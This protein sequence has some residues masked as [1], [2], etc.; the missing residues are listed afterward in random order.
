MADLSVVP[1]RNG[2]LNMKRGFDIGAGPSRGV[3]AAVRVLE[4]LVE[5]GEL[6]E[7]SVRRVAWMQDWETIVLGEA[8]VAQWTREEHG[9][10][11]YAVCAPAELARILETMTELRAHVPAAHRKAW[12]E[13][14]TF[15]E[16]CA[17]NGG[18]VSLYYDPLG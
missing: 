4:D 5:D 1:Y 16:A 12:D 6:D 2:D 8:P 7:E 10:T 13:L 9:D 15:L 14:A 17:N 11:I 3:E 18:T